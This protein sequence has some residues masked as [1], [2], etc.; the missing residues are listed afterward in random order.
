MKSLF[1]VTLVTSLLFGTSVLAKEVRLYEDSDGDKVKICK[2]DDGYLVIREDGS[3]PAWGTDYTWD[4]LEEGMDVN[5][6]NYTEFK[7]GKCRNEEP[8][9]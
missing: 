6:P 5:T 9:T 2:D 7:S 3:G 4:D 1:K 8:P